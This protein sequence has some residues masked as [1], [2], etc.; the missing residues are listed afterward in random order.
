MDNNLIT[1]FSGILTV[2]GT[3]LS[4]VLGQTAKKH[5]NLKNLET[6]TTLAT[7]AV[8]WAE[9]NFNENPEKLAGAIDYVSKE[10]KI[11][12]LKFEPKLIEAQIETSLAK[13]KQE[14]KANPF[15]TAMSVVNKTDVVAKVVS[16]DVAKVANNDVVKQLETVIPEI[17]PIVNQTQVVVDQAATEAEALN[18]LV[19]PVLN[20][21][22]GLIS[23]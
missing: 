6:L 4:Y 13:L 20:A 7:Q 19:T 9:K 14:F 16:E 3:L 8:A 21:T 15:Q 22:E 11:L 5:A 23:K 17:K 10:A 1:L 18:K 12:K 2:A